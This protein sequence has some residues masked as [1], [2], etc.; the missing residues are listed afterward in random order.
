MF[1]RCSRY[2]FAQSV[3]RSSIHLQFDKQLNLGLVRSAAARES[4]LDVDEFEG[5]LQV[6]PGHRTQGTGQECT[7]ALAAAGVQ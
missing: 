3:S 4:G 2:T 6:G 1:L 5:R 7:L